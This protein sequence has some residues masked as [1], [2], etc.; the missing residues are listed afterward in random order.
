M[1]LSSIVNRYWSIVLSVLILILSLFIFLWPSQQS[2]LTEILNSGLIYTNT[3]DNPA[4]AQQLSD[5][6]NGKPSSAFLFDGIDD[7]VLKDSINIKNDFSFCFWLKPLPS[8][9]DQ[10]LFLKG[11]NCPDG[12]P[13]F[14]GVSFAVWIQPNGKL[15]T[16]IVATGG[17]HT[18]EF[19]TMESEK[20]VRKFQWT[21]VSI[22]YDNKAKSFNLTFN[23]QPQVV[24][25]I[26]K[27]SPERFTEI[28]QSKSPLKIGADENYC[29]Y[30]HQ[31]L[32]YYHGHLDDVYIFDRQLSSIE[33]GTLSGKSS[34]FLVTKSV[35]LVI[36]FIILTLAIMFIWSIKT[37][38]D[39][40]V[41]IKNVVLRAMNNFDFE[42]VMI[43]FTIGF[44]IFLAVSQF[45]FNRTLWTDELLL[46]TSIIQ[47]NPLLL[48]Q[49]LD[50]YSVAPILFLQ[51]EKLFSLFI[52]D[53]D[54]ALRTLPLI[55]FIGSIYLLFRILTKIHPNKYAVLIGL[56]LFAFNSPLIYYASEIKQ[57]MTDVFAASL[58]Y[59]LLLKD[60]TNDQ[61]KFK[62]LGIAGTVFIF[63][64]N[65]APIILF[66]AGVFLVFHH[67][68]KDVEIRRKLIK[69]FSVWTISFGIYYYFFIWRHPATGPMLNYWT[70]LDVFC[71]KPFTEEFYIFILNKL[72]SVRGRLFQFGIVGELLINTLLGAGILSL[73]LRRKVGYLILTCVPVFLH[74]FLSGLKMY[75]FDVRLVLYLCPI[76]IIISSFGVNELINVLFADLKI[77]RIRFLALAIP[78]WFSTL[79]YSNGFYWT[80]FPFKKDESK[81]SIGY[82]NENKQPEDQIYV[83]PFAILMFNYYHNTN[84]LP[85][86]AK[87]IILGRRLGTM[88]EEAQR[89]ASLHGR[90][91]IITGG[92]GDAIIVKLN[93][94]GHQLEDEFKEAGAFLFDFKQI[95]SQ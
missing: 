43:F 49:P 23:D 22:R 93:E 6:R 78:I 80:S 37:G 85:L 51:L 10:M 34:G 61:S 19:L 30:Q 77:E 47:R 87:N 82:V 14:V 55:A 18:D 29:G 16:K 53:T 74:L 46:A 90:V 11:E 26:S 48:L 40:I 21:F 86:N 54:L 7:F 73:I 72:A 83:M 32:N 66:T 64:S 12:S 4:G 94:L 62:Y 13:H 28:H 2:S 59:F 91:W 50:F 65:V 44:G 27:T 9:K 36:S 15:S 3:F 75:P 45:V 56:A 57:Y 89:I 84:G 95:P 38:N 33:L 79:F 63:L 92:D 42:D 5:D 20:S 17:N 31:F 71:P 24:R 68:L 41:L 39:I 60:Y 67:G 58:I 25:L 35:P 70:Q 8:D 88:E 1:N 52:P 76:F 69:I 81:K